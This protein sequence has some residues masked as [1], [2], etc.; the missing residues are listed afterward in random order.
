MTMTPEVCKVCGVDPVVVTVR[1]TDQRG[2]MTRTP[3][4]GSC[5]DKM[6]AAVVSGRAAVDGTLHVPAYNG[7]AC[8]DFLGC[9]PGTVKMIEN[10]PPVFGGMEIGEA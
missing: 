3:M 1:A 2:R 10:T 7:N 5:A 9:G 6:V 8:L 4:C